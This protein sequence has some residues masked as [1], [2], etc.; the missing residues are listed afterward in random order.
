MVICGSSG[1]ILAD[2]FSIHDTRK[3]LNS[4]GM[5]L[6]SASAIAQKGFFAVKVSADICGPGASKEE[7]DMNAFPGTREYVSVSVREGSKFDAPSVHLKDSIIF[8]AY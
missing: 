8:L 5:K 7:G 3:G 6:Q 1:R 2:G 4:G